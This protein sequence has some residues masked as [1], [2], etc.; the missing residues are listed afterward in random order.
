MTTR[1]LRGVSEVV[2]TVL[3]FAIVVGLI[4]N[5]FLFGLPLLRKEMDKARVSYLEKAM[6]ELADAIEATAREGGETRVRIE[7]KGETPVVIKLT[8]D[9]TWGGYEIDLRGS[10]KYTYYAPYDVPRNDDLGPFNESGRTGERVSLA[11]GTL[12]VNRGVVLTA[13]ST[14]L[15]GG[16]RLTMRLIPR[17]LRDPARGKLTWIKLSPITGKSTR[18]T[19][20][21]VV[22][23][24][25]LGETEE[26]VVEGG[27]PVVYRII[28][29]GVGFE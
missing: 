21:T 17:P 25:K 13:R 1:T 8:Y 2:G 29:V 14:K 11:V 18:D 27:T 16:V 12:G 4:S 15:M 10:S 9:S 28:T 24:K 5:A 26:T 23:L 20:P 3:T 7:A 22:I 6:S 19:L